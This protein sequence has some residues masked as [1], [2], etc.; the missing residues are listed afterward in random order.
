MGKQIVAK[1]PRNADAHFLLGLAYLEQEKPE[2]A[3]MEFKT[4]NQIGQFG[5]YTDEAVFRRKIAQLYEQFKQPEEALKEY[6][7]LIKREPDKADNYVSAGKLFEQR[8][9]SD[10]AMQ[11]YKKAVELEPRAPDPHFRL[12]VLLYRAKKPQEARSELDQAVKR[13]P[14]NYRAYYYIGKI[15]KD[16]KDYVSAASALEKAQKDP[17]FKIRALVERGGAF[18]SM[19]SIERAIADLERAVKLTDT[20][21]SQESLFAHYFLSLCY[22]KTRR[23]EEAIEQW[24]FIYQ[25]KPNFKDVADK[26]SRYQEL[27]TDDRVKDYMTLGQEQFTVLCRR[28]TESLDLQIRD[29]R[30]ISNGCEIVA[31]EAQSKW[32]NARKLP[33]ILRFL[34]VTDIIDEERVRELHEEMKEQSITRGIVV[35]SSTF[36]RKASDFAETRPI[37]LYGKDRLQ[38]MLSQVKM[39]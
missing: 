27:R 8:H 30:N 6:L 22:E 14:D 12:G 21:D 7:L 11:F 24:E 2:L 18:M 35:T 5:N 28:L 25:K 13:D 1:D 33:K 38:Q 10:K 34:R 32:R 3:L 9:R 16:G 17:E 20:P 39:P 19:N 31:V 37:D 4:V 26:L 15:L 36:S 23:M 29:E